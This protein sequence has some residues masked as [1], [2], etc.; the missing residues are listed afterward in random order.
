MSATD[1][2]NAYLKEKSKVGGFSGSAFVVREGDIMA[3]VSF[4][5]ADKTKFVPNDSNTIFQ[6][7]SVSKQFASALTMKLIEQDK[8]SLSDRL[9]DWIQDAPPAWNKITIR[10]LIN[11]TSGMCHWRDFEGL[12]LGKALDFNEFSSLLFQSPL[13]FMPGDGWYYT[14]PAYVFLAHILELASR[15]PYSQML[16]K[17]IFEPLEMDSTFVGSE[18]PSRKLVAL[19]YSE[20]AEVPSMDLNSLSLGAGD[21]CSTTHDL[22]KWNMSLT[23]PNLILN[24]ASIHTML[25]DE[26]KI[27]EE[28]A[29]NSH[30]RYGYGLYFEEMAGH[31][32]V[33]HTGDNPGFKSVNIQFFEQNTFVV[34]LSNN[35]NCRVGELGTYIVNELMNSPSG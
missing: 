3:D 21:I 32:I 17:Q 22:M 8:L 31:T 14:S 26:V 28:V 9:V 15:I 18:L 4:G 33:Y 11:H 13:K 30:T 35:D 25:N 16:K 19:G 5:Y 7:A 34:L 29:G 24:P 27:P 6:I 12:N 23:V 10:N 20:E 2:I 1:V